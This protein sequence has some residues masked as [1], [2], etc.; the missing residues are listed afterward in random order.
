MVYTESQLVRIAKRENN[1]K[2]NYLVVNGLQGKH[3]PVEPHKA[4]DMFRALSEKIKEKYLN[5]SLLLIGFAET[6]TAI[7]AFAAVYL[8]SEYMQTTRE[9]IPNAEY[10]YFS[11]SHSH[12]TEQRIVKGDLDQI[13]ENIDRIVFVEDEVTTGNT[14]MKIIDII[15]HTYSYQVL[16]SVAS[17]LN[18][19]SKQDYQ[20]YIRQEI[21][22][23]YL[24]RTDH[25]KYEKIANHF[26]GNGTYI[27]PVD[28]D[29]AGHYKRICCDN[30]M[31]ARR[32]VKGEAIRSS[33]ESLW[34]QIRG[35]IALNPD[36]NILVL[37]S[38][39]FMY[40]ALYVAAEIEKAGACVRFHATTRSPI[41][42]SSEAEY[43]VHARF[44]LKSMY[45]TE[46]VTYVYDLK[47]YHKVVILTDSEMKEETGINTLINA[48]RSVEN[49]DITVIRWNN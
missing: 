24:V 49:H 48:L 4:F 35:Q 1:N 6:A 31:N 33:C 26:S 25:S 30:Y 19:M 36:Q 7:G 11:E 10:L 5:E 43:P 17:I 34:K 23:L 38:E 29:A 3:I 21:D 8:N 18:G 13:I 20:N 28:R 40:P 27:E 12:A 16:F 47:K 46:R 22:L 2:R 37:G 44:E 14:I 45:D 15:K 42:V 41:A 39:E 9:D 32:A